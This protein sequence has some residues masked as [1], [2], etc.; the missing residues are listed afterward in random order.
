MV[1]IH[2]EIINK[3]LFQLSRMVLP[4]IVFR[5]ILSSRPGGSIRNAANHPPGR[6]TI[7]ICYFFDPAKNINNSV[8]FAS[9]FPNS[10]ISGF[11]LYFKYPYY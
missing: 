7:Y 3:L 11:V 5:V 1:E 4:D 2:A 9:I 8:C 10:G 6:L